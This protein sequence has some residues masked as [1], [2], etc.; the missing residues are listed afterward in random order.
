MI[1]ITL[2]CSG[3]MRM[4]ATTL[5]WVPFIGA[6]ETVNVIATVKGAHPT[7]TPSL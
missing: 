4:S 6:T 2:A 5:G 1:V 3:L 7:C